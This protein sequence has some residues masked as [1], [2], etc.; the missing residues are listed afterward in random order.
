MRF[1][2]DENCDANL[3]KKLREAGHDVAFVLEDQ[4]GSDDL[5]VVRLA[6]EQNRVILTADLDFGQLSEFERELPP[7]IVLLRL[8][9]LQ[10]AS[11]IER[12]VDVLNS[13]G[14]AIQHNVVVIE[15]GQV[16]VRCLG[17]E[18]SR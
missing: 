18:P 13:L 11:R 9:P 12:I 16:R 4:P 17:P 2:A 7:G 3:V 8:H 14:D 6:R 1:L 10:R 15:P 5:E